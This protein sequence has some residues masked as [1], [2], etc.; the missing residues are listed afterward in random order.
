MSSRLYPEIALHARIAHE[1][2]RRIASGRIAEGD[3]LPREAE[4][5]EEFSAGRQAV[6]EALKVLGAKGMIHAR[7][8]AGTFVRSRSAW[9]MLDPDVLAWHPP[10]ALPEGVLRD[11]VEMRRLIEP[12]AAALA[13]ERATPEEIAR[14]EAALT[15]MRDGLDEPQHFYR[16]DI[17][18]HLA[19]FAASG[20]SLVDRISTILGPLLEASFRL[21][22][23]QNQSFDQ[24]FD[25]HAA[26]YEA[27]AARDADAA[28]SAMERLLDR[29]ITE[30]FA[31]E[32]TGAA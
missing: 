9:N 29:A 4:L 19:I 1:I 12:S 2:G 32:S 18:F 21:Q 23:E 16:A 24:G 10:H 27:I 20:N 25:V 26:V 3:L 31:T 6:R 11:L 22:R 30:V 14:I 5:Q 28:R 13:A 8:R 17:D 7:K 15:R